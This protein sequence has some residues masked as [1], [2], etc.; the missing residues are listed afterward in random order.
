MRTEN[1]H[2]TIA[3]LGQVEAVRFDDIVAAA[4]SVQVQ[5]MSLLLDRPGHWKHNKIAWLG[6]NDVPQEL[7]AMVAAL[8]AALVK[9]RVAFDPKPFVP[10]VTVVRNALPPREDWPTAPPVKW[11]VRGFSLISSERDES[12]PY[13]RVVAGPFEG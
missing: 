13:Y 8:R 1:L 9:A 7:G 4:R 11:P 12:G 10:H 5:P 6:A 3:F 2:I